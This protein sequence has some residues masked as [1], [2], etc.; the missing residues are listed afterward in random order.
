MEGRIDESVKM[1]EW[2][3][4]NGL[5]NGWMGKRDGWVKMSGRMNE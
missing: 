5:M 3:G 2:M 1:N 4:G